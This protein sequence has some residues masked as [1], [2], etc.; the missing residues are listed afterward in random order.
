MMMTGLGKWSALPI[1]NT[2]VPQDVVDKIKTEHGDHLYDIT[3]LKTGEN[4]YAYSARVHDNGVY[5]NIIINDDSGNNNAAPPAN[6][7]TM[8]DSNTNKENNSTTPQ[9]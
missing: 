6:N 4:Q 1:L 8:P 9:Q 7:T 2:Y 5:R 3:M